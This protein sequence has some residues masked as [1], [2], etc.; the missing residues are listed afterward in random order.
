M[1]KTENTRHITELNPLQSNNRSCPKIAQGY[2]L[3]YFLSAFL[4][5]NSKTG[6]SFIFAWTCKYSGTSCFR[7]NRGSYKKS[8]NLADLSISY[9]PGLQQACTSH[10]SPQKQAQEFVLIWQ[11]WHTKKVGSKWWFYALF[12]WN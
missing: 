2:L 3:S 7:E 11:N 6:I 10:K 12:I 5:L 1:Y 8:A 9:P 4:L